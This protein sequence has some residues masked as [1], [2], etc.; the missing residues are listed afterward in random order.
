MRSRKIIKKLVQLTAILLLLLFAF[1]AG[2]Y[3]LLQSS[4]IQTD[5]ANRV[6]KVV[7]E[8][9]NTTFS[10]SKINISFLYRVRLDD[11][12]LQDLSGDTLLYAN[13]ITAG[14]RYIRPVR[15]KI[16]IGSI[17]I[18]NAFVSLAIDS[19]YNLNLN[20][21]ID[22]LNGNGNG[23]GGWDVRFNNVKLRHSRF[24]LKNY[25][26]QPV[27]FGMNYSDIRVYDLE[28]DI[29]QFNPS[30][31]SLSF[32]IK[33]L[34]LKERGGF[35]LDKLSSRF[36]QSKSFLSFRE[37]AIKTPNSSIEGDEITLHFNSW[38]AFKADSFINAVMF[39]INLANSTIN[40]ND[41]GYFAPSFQNTDQFVTL[42]GK[43]NG[44][45]GN[46]KGRDLEFGFGNNSR[47]AGELSIEGL[48][49]IKETFIH[50]DIKELV[51]S[52]NDLESLHL[53]GQNTILLPDLVNKLGL[54]TYQGSF[55]GFIND[56]VAYGTF[57]TDLGIVKTDL[58]FRPDTLNLLDFEGKL[59]VQ[60]FDL[61]SLLDAS[62][63]VGRISLKATINGATVTGKSIDAALKGVIERFEFRKYEY[64]NI[65]LAGNLNGKT[66]NGSIN[67]KDPNIDLEFLGEVNLSDSIPVFNFKA[68]VTDANLFALNINRSDPD[69]RVSCYL[70]ANARGNSINTLNGEIKV[71]NSLFVKK[72]KQLQIYD[73]SLVAENYSGNNKLR[74]RSDFI[75]AD[76]T[77]N[78]ELTKISETLK[79]Y[80]FSC[81]PS[82]VDSTKIPDTQLQNSVA[83]Q[84]TIKNVKPLFDFF[85]PDYGIAENS[86]IS[87]SYTPENEKM[88][89]HF[90]TSRIEAKG[91]AWNGLNLLID[92]NDKSLVIE[93]GGN[94]LSL[95]NRVK[96]ENFTFRANTA[97]DT[98]GILV[99][100]NNWQDLQYRGTISALAKVSRPNGS[101]NARLDVFLHPTS[102]ITNDTLWNIQAGR[103][104]IDTTSLLFDNLV[105]NHRDEYFRLNGALSEKSSE[106]LT[107][108][109]NHFN[110][111]NLNG[112]TMTS[113]YRLGG[114]VDGKAT[115]ADVYHN[116]LFTSLLKIDSLMI[117]NEI[118]GNTQITSKWDADRKAIDLEAQAIRDNLKII[119]IKGEYLPAEKGKLAFDLTL[120]KLRIN[121][122]NPY[123]SVVFSDLR[124]MASGKASLTGTLAKPLLNGELNLQ[125][126]TF[127]VNYLQTRYTFSEKVQIENNNIYFKDIR[128]YDAKSHSAYL[129]GAIRNKYLKDFHLDLNIRSQNFMCLNT[130]QADN[131]NFY[132][133]AFA[134]G[135]IKIS[136]PP[137][138]IIMDISARTEKDTEISIPL[139]N[140]GE[141]DEYPYITI[142]NEDTGGG[143][144]LYE[145]DYQVDLS[146]MQI[147]FDLEMTPDAEV[148]IIFDPKLGDKIKGTGKGNLD[149]KINT[150][151]DFTM[152][153]NYVIEKGD[154][155]FTL[156][157]FINR[158][159]TIESG[160]NIRWN[161]DPLDATIDIVAY[162]RTKASLSDLYGAQAENSSKIWVH[163]RI[164]MTGKL[165]SPDVK[166][167]IDLPEA[168]ESTKLSLNSAISSS[169]E[170]NKQFLSI[171]IQNRFLP[172]SDNQSGSS[173]TS[174]SS[175]S[176]SS[177]AGANVSEFMSNQLSH[178]LSQLS[179][180][181]DVNVNY[182]TDRQMKSDE[183]Q[184][185]LS[186]QLFNDRLTINGSVD[187]ATNA[188]A[189]ASDEIVG[190]FDVDYKLTKNG[191]LRL[192]T[193]NH[194]INDMLYKNSTYTQ[195]FG[196]SYKEE[197]NTF[198]ELI[199]RYFGAVFGK[200]EEEPIPVTLEEPKTEVD[201]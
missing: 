87:F 134:T 18:D 20:Y 93:A 169:D 146:G 153:G 39:R 133:T 41:I 188:T 159:L 182:R 19:A 80:F 117:N 104:S 110:L 160:G 28:A 118:L 184:V 181:V 86:T 16:S 70:I 8:N 35:I 1:P 74:L 193:Y 177:A 161:G 127:T 63:S 73:L 147:N 9:L 21:I 191:K 201:N 62:N 49:R 135:V 179:D 172:S 170:L 5:V 190:E 79:Q 83:L 65:N 2:A 139:N 196:F 27:G 105:I 126:T 33:M 40:L 48:P 116:M 24:S 165:M 58:L 115:I 88:L 22:K 186:T 136:G 56:F 199:K 154:Y 156:Q 10:I 143:T 140:V 121:L 103:I 98:A 124:G 125:K 64:T 168:D 194:A 45:I 66:F 155:L 50:A 164:T 131:K 26:Y 95:K 138:N 150:A 158:E 173:Q 109:F 166:Y 67:I 128:I 57:N 187:M 108:L 76:L 38:K 81:F 176:Y 12:Y 174:S 120:D 130:T 123:V 34:R 132:G 13:S 149:M 144:D 15:K 183:V 112:F 37:I 75:D 114:I 145:A 14:I 185:A 3:L 17:D 25:Y 101:H 94:N 189:D 111:G 200:K 84:S 102:F 106:Q 141:L 59:S 44:P 6:M 163:D 99:R 129:S 11:V 77:G 71:L 54:V 53:P 51:T 55:T 100:W 32:Y 68:N 92:G 97:E 82:L 43:V 167:D 171:L 31:D 23:K 198:N 142:Y 113:G 69:F 96:L 91:F 72:Q 36:S 29:K 89:L 30:K 180:D 46:I 175:S 178:L 47:L 42:S 197:F 162:Y 148:Q 157:N 122:F 151:G 60:D 52:A 152:F 107:I 85:L 195:G 192:K 4:R 90:Q 7:S 61:G 78:Y 119:D 137:K